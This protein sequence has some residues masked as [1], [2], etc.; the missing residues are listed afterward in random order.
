MLAIISDLHF[1][2]GT[3]TKKNVNPEAFRLALGVPTSPVSSPSRPAGTSQV[4]TPLPMTLSA[5]GTLTIAAIG[6]EIRE[7]VKVRRV[8]VEMYQPPE[9]RIIAPRLEIK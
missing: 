8:V 2:D 1:C 6:L 3:A 9:S 5:D 7:G 4:S